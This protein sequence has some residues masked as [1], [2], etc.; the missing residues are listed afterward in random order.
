MGRLTPEDSTA[1]CSGSAFRLFHISSS[2]FIAASG[3]AE[4]DGDKRTWKSPDGSTSN[5]L[6]P[7]IPYLK[8]LIGKDGRTP[9]PS[10]PSNQN[11]KSLWCFEHESRAML[12]PCSWEQ[13]VRIRHV[14]SGKYLAI[15][16]N[17]P[18]FSGDIEERPETW[19]STQLVDDAYDED[20]MDVRDEPLVL[21]DPPSMLFYFTPTGPDNGSTIPNHDVGVRLV[22]RFVDIYGEEQIVYLHNSETTKPS[23]P[24]QDSNGNPL[25]ETKNYHLVFANIKSVQDSLKLLLSTREEQ[26]AVANVK[27]HMISVLQY[28]LSMSDPNIKMSDRDF[29]K[30]IVK[31]FLSLISLQIKGYKPLKDRDWIQVSNEM[32]PLAF[33]NLF[34]GVPDHFMQ[35]LCRDM[36][37]L[38]AMYIT[39][40]APYKRTS[41]DHPFDHPN[42]KNEMNSARAIQKF[43]HVVLQLMMKQNPVSQAY[44]GNCRLPGHSDKDRQLFMDNMMSQLEDPLGSAVTLSQLLNSSS[45][46]MERYASKDL[47]DKFADMIYRLGPQPRLISFFSSVC[48]VN[49][50]PIKANQEMILRQIWL[51][52][53]VREKL[54]VQVFT[55]PISK[56]PVNSE[57]KMQDTDRFLSD[58]TKFPEAYIGKT[59]A[60][61]PDFFAPV[62]ITWPSSY[63][64]K[65]DSAMFHGPDELGYPVLPYQMGETENKMIVRIEDLCWVLAPEKLCRAVTGSGWTEVKSEIEEDKDKEER[66]KLQIQ[67][68]SYLVGQIDLLSLMCQG[69]S[70]NCISWL[71]KTFSYPML[72]SLVTNTLLPPKMRAKWTGF[73]KALYLDRYP[74][75]PLMGKPQLPDQVGV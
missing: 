44:F 20:L 21:A 63:H 24:K 34:S 22:H 56:R 72:V 25:P 48:S 39:T 13:P 27:G 51:K 1:L 6:P 32:L 46:L 14:P 38:D 67:I 12:G 33:C 5:N 45:D 62:Y 40:L 65:Q 54:L 2:S 68:A 41:P 31:L 35:D 49:G 70:S 16:T 7:H 64:W 60:E 30:I 59:E 11:V 57:Y 75:L 50:T 8:K 15:N 55:E 28:S 52:E 18:L 47:V 3:N 61:S 73:V 36:K 74:Q 26:R 10:D 37:L 23:R 29:N 19:Y 69:R 53:E 42:H 43:C 4:K 9:D 71:E 66:H 17:Q 58:V